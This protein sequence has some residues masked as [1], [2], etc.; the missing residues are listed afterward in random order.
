MACAHEDIEGYDQSCVGS[1]KH[2]GHH[3][4]LSRRL[5]NHEWTQ[6]SLRNDEAWDS[7]IK[8]WPSDRVIGLVKSIAP[9]ITVVRIDTE[10]NSGDSE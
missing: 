3:I 10:E 8:N 6:F 9:D 5:E 2:N 4:V 1:V 7:D